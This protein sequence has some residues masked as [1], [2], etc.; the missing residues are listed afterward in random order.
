VVIWDILGHLGK[1]LGR[2]VGA[3]A[4]KRGSHLRATWEVCGS[5]QKS[6]RKP[7]GGTWDLGAPGSYPKLAWELLGGTCGSYLGAPWRPLGGCLGATAPKHG[8]HLGT[9]RNDLDR[10]PHGSHLIG[11]LWSDRGAHP[12][13]PGA[14]IGRHRAALQPLGRHL[15]ISAGNWETL[16]SH[17]GAPQSA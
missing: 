6:I 12:E 14:P 5:Q 2:Y 13:H 1:H 10:K 4:P 11:S 17:V 3:T 15:E 16:G 9:P 7:L 8:S